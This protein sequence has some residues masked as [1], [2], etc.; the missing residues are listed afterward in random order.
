MMLDFARRL[1]DVVAIARRN[2]QTS[3]SFGLGIVADAILESLDTADSDFPTINADAQSVAR[4]IEI[5]RDA[6]EVLDACL[7]I[8][9]HLFSVQSGRCFLEF[10]LPQDR[11]DDSLMR[12]FDGY[13]RKAVNDSAFVYTVCALQREQYLYLARCHEGSTQT[14]DPSTRAS[15]LAALR[16]GSQLAVMRPSPMTAATVIDIEAAIFAVFE[17]ENLFA[18]VS[19]RSKPVRAARGAAYLAELSRLFH[20]LGLKFQSPVLSASSTVI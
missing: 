15:L 19:S 8:E 18:A 10:A 11:S 4:G 12:F 20:D 17:S 3:L 6:T 7:L 2:S 16:Q 13:V 14:L 9:S 1:Q 5:V